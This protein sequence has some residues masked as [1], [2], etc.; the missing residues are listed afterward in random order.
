M[1]LIEFNLEW[2][3]GLDTVKTQDVGKI[4]DQNFQEAIFTDGAKYFPQQALGTT[5][6]HLYNRR[7]L[8][9]NPDDNYFFDSPIE[10]NVPSK[11][12]I[13]PIT[14]ADMKLTGTYFDSTHTPSY[15]PDKNGNIDTTFDLDHFRSR[16]KEFS[17]SENHPESFLQLRFTIFV[18]I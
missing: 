5:T 14:N 15:Y 18:E 7:A 4:G 3:Y 13:V 8:T 6:N 16:S 17:T 1:R 11:T 12:G 9:C 10:N 2:N